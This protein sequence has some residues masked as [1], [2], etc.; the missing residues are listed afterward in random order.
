M[1]QVKIFIFEVIFRFYNKGN[2]ESDS[3]RSRRIDLLIYKFI[4]LRIYH[5][6]LFCLIYYHLVTAV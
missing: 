4:N 3:D 6:K 2:T 1:N 5:I